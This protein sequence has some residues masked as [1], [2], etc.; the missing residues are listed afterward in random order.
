MASPFPG[1][2][3]YL[4]GEMWM[5]FH[6]RLANQ[7]SEQLLQKLPERYTALLNKHYW[8]DDSALEIISQARSIYPD[9]HVVEASRAQEALVE[10]VVAGIQEEIVELVSPIPQEIPAL[11]VEI[12][13][14]AE[15]R[16]VTVIE[17]L[18]PGNKRGKGWED[19]NDKRVELLGTRTHL[20][21]ID[22]LRAGRR[23]YL[24]GELPS[25]PYFVFLSRV[26][27]RPRTTVFP[28]PLRGKLPTIPIPLLPPDA[29][30]A[31]D[32]QAA[33]DACFNLVHYE[34]LLDYTK[35][36]PP[37]ELD[38]ED[39]QWVQEKIRAAGYIKQDGG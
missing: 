27:R 7:I 19:Y 33:V 32:L 6:D 9:V 30:V 8:L 28:I 3:P 29:D 16:L 24:I 12:R 31:F 15:R 14:V 5:E 11:S 26:Q 36:L 35:A 1:M 21:E 34:R 4:E 38:A 10:Y 37:P 2:D 39:A 22:L 23:I 17:I 13:D 18:S 20:V 25:V